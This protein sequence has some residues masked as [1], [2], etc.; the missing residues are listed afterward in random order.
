MAQPVGKVKYSET[1]NQS[2]GRKPGSAS[3]KI[4]GPAVGRASGNK[5]KGGGVFQP[6]KG[7][8]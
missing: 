4:N 3:K 2:E 5:T 6:T 7:K 1:D 8:M